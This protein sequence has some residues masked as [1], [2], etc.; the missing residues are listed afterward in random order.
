MN[1]NSVNGQANNKVNSKAKKENNNNIQKTVNIQKKSNEGSSN[2]PVKVVQCPPPK[3][4]PVP[5]PK[6]APAPAPT[7][8]PA[9]PPQLSSTTAIQI[10]NAINRLS[11]RQSLPNNFSLESLNLPPGITITKVD[12]SQVSQQRRPITQVS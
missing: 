7:P 12:P 2:V 4:A 10:N 9:P 11:S 5:A 8:A 3:V 6:P 1:Q